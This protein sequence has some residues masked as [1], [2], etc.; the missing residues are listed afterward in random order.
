MTDLDTQIAKAHAA[1]EAAEAEARAIEAR[2]IKSGITPPLRRYGSK[3][4]LSKNLTAQGLLQVKDPALAA[5]LGY[6]SD[7]ARKRAEEAAARELQ[8]ERMRMM[9]A[10]TKA[11]NDAAAAQR[12][13]QQ[14]AG[15]N[16]NTGRR[17]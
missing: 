7:I 5:F 3:V 13:Q 10:Q 6:G 16:P 14:L 15:I 9:T 8:A 17:W 4:D 12:Y 11:A 2:L 1:A